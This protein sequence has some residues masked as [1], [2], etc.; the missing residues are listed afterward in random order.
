MEQRSGA[1][2]LRVALGNAY[3]GHGAIATLE[4]H[5]GLFVSYPEWRIFCHERGNDVTREYHGCSWI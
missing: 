3:A 2:L 1:S 5:Y 4:T